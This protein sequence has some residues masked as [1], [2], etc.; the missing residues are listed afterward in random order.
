MEQLFLY[1]AFGIG[2]EAILLYFLYV[3]RV[4]LCNGKLRLSIIHCCLERDS[5]SFVN[6]TLHSLFFTAGRRDYGGGDLRD[7]LDRRISPRRKY[8]PP[9]DVRGRDKFYG[10]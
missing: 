3:I 4:V 5:L 1:T 9:Q 8:S 6:S 7:R 2:K 10:Q